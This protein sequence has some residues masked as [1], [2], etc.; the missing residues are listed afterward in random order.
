MKK[1]YVRILF[2]VL[3]AAVLAGTSGTVLAIPSLQLDIAGGTYDPVTET[4]IASSTPFT[5]YAYL[6]PDSG[7]PLTGTYYIS[8][9]I[10]PAVGPEEFTMRS[11]CSPVIMSLYFP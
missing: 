1:I 8:A 11:N 10:L 5:L 6:V 9:A 7:A 3:T 4:I 2:V